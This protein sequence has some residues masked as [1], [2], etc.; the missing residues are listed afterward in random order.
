MASILRRF[1]RIP[2]IIQQLH[3]RVQ[4]HNKQEDFQDTNLCIALLMRF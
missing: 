4:T 2:Y 3:S 1:M